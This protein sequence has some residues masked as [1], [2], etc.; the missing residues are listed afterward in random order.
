MRNFNK[1]QLIC[2]ILLIIHLVN[3]N[4]T[5]ENGLKPNCVNIKNLFNNEG[6]FSN[7]KIKSDPG[8]SIKIKF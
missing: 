6:L 8:K 4:P 5:E 1:N 2:S 3:C 7:A